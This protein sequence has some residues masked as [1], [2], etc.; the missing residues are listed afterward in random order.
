MRV[1]DILE[2]L[3][4]YAPFR[5]AEAWDN[6][7]LLVGDPSA[8]VD[9]VLV[10]LD[11]GLQTI[12]EAERRGA[13]CL[14]T[15]H[16]VILQPLKMVRLDVYPGS[17]VARALKSGISLIAAHTNLDAAR[18]GTNERLA[19]MLSL[20]RIEALESAPAWRHEEAYGGMG[21][22]GLLPRSMSLEELVEYVEGALGGIIARAV[23]DPGGKVRKV[24]LCTG[25]GASLMHHAPA[26]GSQAYITGDVK[27]HDAQWA[28][29]AGLSLIDIGHFASERLIV[30]PLADYLRS[31]SSGEA[32]SLE[33]IPAVTERDPFWSR[34]K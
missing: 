13:Q 30:E 14:V 12:A 6:C 18:E 7:G 8:V 5:Y 2:W 31:R 19:R 17:V 27:Y 16:P 20:E 34:R 15:H 11:P 33:V 26:N 32:V 22:V 4:A 3:D 25:S 28:V 9:R 10:A 1:R 23:G 29:E 21:R 24:S